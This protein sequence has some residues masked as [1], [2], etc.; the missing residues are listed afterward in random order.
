MCAEAA[1][2]LAAAVEPRYDLTLH[3]LHLALIRRPA[4]VSWVTGVAQAAQKGAFA[5]LNLGAGLPKSSSRPAS[6]NEL[7]RPGQSYA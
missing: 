1:R 6:T 3:V 7:Y 2:R 4:R 5:I